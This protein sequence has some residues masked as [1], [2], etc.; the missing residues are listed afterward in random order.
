[1]LFVGLAAALSVA[2]QSSLRPPLPR[3]ALDSFP[4]E[5]RDAL[6]R[7]YEAATA[8][9][10]DVQAV[11][12]LARSLHAW[13]QWS[14]AHETYA[15]AQALAP[16]A[17]EW[18]YLDG[19][20]L[21]RLARHA[22]AA[23]RFDEA[24]LRSP[25]Y[26]PTRVN[27]A[28][29]LLESGNLNRAEQLFDALRREPAAEP[30][31]E[32]GLGRI[33]TATGHHDRA[34]THLER[35]VALFP[36][37]GAAYY[38]LALAYRAVGR[39]D[40]AE[41]ALQ[42]NAQYGARWPALDDPVFAAVTALRDDAETKLQ[43]GLKLAE[44]GDLAGAIR[45]HE[46]ALA[47]DP[48]IAQAHV[49]LIALYGRTGDWANAERHYRAVLAL[50]FSL[51][52][53]HYDYGVLLG[54]Q[55]KWALAADAYRQAIATNPRHAPAHNNLGQILEREHRLEE[56]A[57]AYRHAVD[58]QPTFR[59]ARFNLGRMLIALNRPDDAIVELEAL[60]EPRDAET[61]RYVFALAT[62]HVR[63]G[64]RDEGIKRAVEARQLALE[65]GQAELAAAIERDL[66][67][68]K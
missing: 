63:A 21:Q 47:R 23:I 44:A 31:A 53:A 18:Q 14:A 16:T 26:L 20:A 64:H 5:A 32:L 10:T 45:Q 59:V 61:P 3:L 52:E 54:L 57:V 62:A 4:A 2:A 7:P 39:V 49:N 15:R 6:A 35:A 43:R 8:R 25:G 51:D 67:R 41:R 38:T 24:L 40:D 48:T 12:A 13:N 33:A 29:S 11:G 1:M 46:A 66:A 55:E 9:P 28:E 30:A 37:W 65:Y 34:V 17:F 36:E 58:S 50:G 60:T 68:L 22:D 27:L 56:A 19:L 42:S